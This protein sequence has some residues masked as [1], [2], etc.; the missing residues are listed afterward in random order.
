MRTTNSHSDK[1]GYSEIISLPV[2]RSVSFASK[3]HRQEELLQF[4][5]MQEGMAVCRKRENLLAM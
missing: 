1:L 3:T 5:N 2:L 4:R